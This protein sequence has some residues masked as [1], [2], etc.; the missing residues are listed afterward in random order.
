MLNGERNLE[1]T[2]TWL[3][4]VGTN[5]AV[6]VKSS[7]LTSM[8]GPAK[9]SANHVICLELAGHTLNTLFPSY[10]YLIL[11]ELQR[12]QKRGRASGKGLSDQTQISIKLQTVVQARY[13]H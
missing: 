5:S 7:V 8:K 9:I 1:R 3:A 13:I 2:R 12:A 11:N 6:A 10:F 4:L